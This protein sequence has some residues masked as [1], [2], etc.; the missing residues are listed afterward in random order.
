VG[1]Y[2]KSKG[3]TVPSHVDSRD[4]TAAGF[5]DFVNFKGRVTKSEAAIKGFTFQ[6]DKGDQN[7]GKEVVG[8][9]ALGSDDK[10]VSYKVTS[11]FCDLDNSSSFHGSVVVLVLAEA[12]PLHDASAATPPI[13][14]K[15]TTINF[16]ASPKSS[17]ILPGSVHFK[18]PVKWAQAMLKGFLMEYVNTDQDFFLQRVGVNRVTI[19]GDVVNFETYFQLEDVM[20]ARGEN[21]AKSDKQI[22][23]SIDVVVLAALKS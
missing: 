20:V 13:D 22:R 23:G 19:E 2:F 11:H 18:R 10:R 14:F 16:E 17:R 1:F 3:T 6:Y 9:R 12:W 5:G 8:I 15:S 21:P 7:F 4:S